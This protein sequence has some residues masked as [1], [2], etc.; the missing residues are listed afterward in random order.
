MKRSLVLN[1]YVSV[2]G[3]SLYL[4]Q[5]THP[6]IAFSVNLLARF[7]FAPTIR[8]WNGIKNIFSDELVG[9]SDA[10]YLSDP[11][12][13]RSQTGYVFTMG[14]TVICWT[15]TK[16]TLVTTYSNHYEIIALH[17]AVKECIWLR[18]IITHIRD[19]SG[20]I[21]TTVEPTCIYEVNVACIEQMKLGLI[22]GVTQHIFHQSSLIISNNK[23]C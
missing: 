14:N 9:F 5:W 11:H 4:A 10:G 1:P 15:S 6:D 19:A 13:G 22:K 12:K 2:V 17:E 3:A 21:S 16:Q 7:N 20:L 23:R 18:A 8:H